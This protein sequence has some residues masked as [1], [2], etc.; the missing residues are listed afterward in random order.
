MLKKKYFWGGIDVYKRQ[1]LDI[2]E[3]YNEKITD[4]MLNKNTYGVGTEIT[5]VDRFYELIDKNGVK[6]YVGNSHY[7]NNNE[8]Y[9]D[10]NDLCFKYIR[11][12][13]LY[14]SRC[15]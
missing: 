14:T 11:Y 2:V 10:K 6:Y 1:V 5:N 4:F 3:E 15:V 9:V 7:N 13:L 12:C 8:W